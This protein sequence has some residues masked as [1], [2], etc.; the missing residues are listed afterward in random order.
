MSN[1]SKG[2]NVLKPVSK[3]RCWAMVCW[4]ISAAAIMAADYFSGPWI[5]FPIMYG[6]P[7]GLAAWFNGRWWAMPIAVLMPMGR[8][9]F[10]TLWASPATS[11]EIAI[12]TVIRILV[13]VSLAYLVDKVATQKRVL[14]KEIQTLHGILPIC[15]F[16]K[17]IRDPAGEWQILEKYISQRSEAQFSHGICPECLRKHYP[18]LNQ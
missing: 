17:R 5:Q 7:V 9:W 15:G 6:I 18:D 11:A 12:N 4:V 10:S 3:T 13:F 8:I 2:G 1:P 14:E 16:C